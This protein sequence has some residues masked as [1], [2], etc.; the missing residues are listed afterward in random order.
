MKPYLYILA[1]CMCLAA[2]GAEA[3]PI[4]IEEAKEINASGRPVKY[5]Q[6]V[7]VSGAVTVENGTFSTQNLDIH[8]QDETAGLFVFLAGGAWARLDLGDSVIVTGTLDVEG[9]SPRRNHTKLIVQ[10]ID[11]I[12]IV[13][14]AEVPAP[15]TVTAA[16]LA[17][18]SEPPLEVYEGLLVRV[19]GLTIDPADWP[20]VPGTE[21]Y[22]T[23]TDATGQLQI[24]LDRDTDLP[25]SD[26]PSSP[27]IAIGVIMQDS[28]NPFRGYNLWPRSRF[29]DLLETGNGSGLAALEPR[30]VEIDDGRFDLAITLE[31]NGV[32]T[33]VAFEISLPFADGWSWDGGS[34]EVSLTGPGLEEAAFEM[35]ATGVKVTGA[36]IQGGSSYGVVT[37]RRILP[38][39]EAKES[40]VEI[41]TSVDGEIFEPI[42]LYPV[43]YALLPI[44]DVVV[45]EVFPD[46]GSTE[47]S[48]AFIELK[49]RGGTAASL[50]GLTLS[51][52]TKESYCAP[53]ARISFGASDGIPAGGYLVV[54][55]SQAGFSERFG[56]EPDFTAGISPLGRLGGDGATADGV[57]AYEVI[58]FWRGVAGGDIVDYCEYKSA[59]LVEKDICSGL[60]GNDD[61]FPL[62]P[63]AAYALVR[64]E[65]AGDAGSSVLD[66]VMSSEP[67]PGARNIAED[68]AP[69]YVLKV[70]PYSQDVIE[71]HFNEPCDSASLAGVSAYEVNGRK[72]LAAYA[73]LSLQ[74]V[75]L[76]FEDFEADTEVTL[77][78]R[79]MR[80]LAGNVAENLLYDFTTSLLGTTDIC[81]VQEYDYKGYSPMLGEIVT[82]IGFIT[83]PQGTFQPQYNSIYIQGLDGCGVNVFSYDPPSP[84]PGLGDLVRVTGEVEEYVSGTAG[85]TTEL[86]MA[87]PSAEVLLSSFYPDLE[88]F[89][90]KT[91]E[92]GIEDNEGK[93][94]ATEGA[95]VSANEFGF[96]VND[97]SGGIQVYQN[98]TDMDYT[99]FHVGMY[100][101]LRGLILQ[102][103]RTLPF[104]AG[105]E[106]VPRWLSDIEVLD[107]A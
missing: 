101:K 4:P 51:D 13:G 96:Y 90:L 45:N 47:E 12:E 85:A 58:A 39:S 18:P 79:E 82:V 30:S 11:D 77:T 6:T 107:D 92:I 3:A 80:D 105:Y 87:G 2:A 50:E 25:G 83:V 99:K 24:R 55:E 81:T 20:T 59:L 9:R 68:N 28:T 86:Y 73:S 42:A 60:G 37:F 23:A 34:R 100:V 7:S 103:D 52:L 10:S 32:D 97:G 41:S 49:N 74:K 72:P 14:E 94:I 75:A 95:I 43:I 8:I 5:K 69:P 35:T 65:D 29:G 76:L 63:P 66:F 38:P 57:E 67:T 46:D 71:V 84:N 15:V 48:N 1:L 64:D 98:Y 36:A 44:P 53:A 102:Y 78:V 26:P 33:I 56:M 89:V 27:F 104:L 54:A 17:V 106:L 31:G 16:E 19:E 62:V 93:L 22:V 91:G 61:A 70:A 88:P 40:E 21:K